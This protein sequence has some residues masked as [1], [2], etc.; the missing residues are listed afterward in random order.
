MRHEVQ[1]PKPS[2]VMAMFKEGVLGAGEVMEIPKAVCLHEEDAGVLWKHM[3]YRT[4]QQPSS[5]PLFA[6]AKPAVLCAITS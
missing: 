2:V 3:D 1:I 4:G 6:V 5:V